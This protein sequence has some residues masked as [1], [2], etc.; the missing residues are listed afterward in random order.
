MRTNLLEPEFV[1]FMPD[2]FEEGILYVSMQYSTAVHLCCCGCKNKVITPL[3]PVDWKLTFDGETI[4]I[5]P[6]IGNWNFKCQSHY[7]IKRNKIN[8]ST[9][10]TKQE[11][12]YVRN[13]DTHRKK[14]YFTKIDTS[15]NY[16]VGSKPNVKKGFFSKL[17]KFFY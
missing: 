15:A 13:L 4:T 2:K 12:D 3:A 10:M 8:W 17:F 11:I 9:Q 16:D 1:E 6:S 7:W 14:E 5:F